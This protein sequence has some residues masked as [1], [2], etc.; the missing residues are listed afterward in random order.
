MIKIFPYRKQ[1]T[2]SN[3]SIDYLGKHVLWSQERKEKHY[4]T[5]ICD[6]RHHYFNGNIRYV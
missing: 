6:T 4:Q 1:P 2:A 3:L 5:I